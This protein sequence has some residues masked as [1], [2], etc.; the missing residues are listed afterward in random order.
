M[1]PK[2]KGHSELQKQLQLLEENPTVSAE[3]TP[4]T[5][6]VF[7][8]TRAYYLRVYMTAVKTVTDRTMFPSMRS[9]TGR[10]EKVP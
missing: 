7:T 9:S 3:T 1:N 5:R 10:V 8:N 6:D 4:P 2:T